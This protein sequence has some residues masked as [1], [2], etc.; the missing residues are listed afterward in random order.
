MPQESQSPSPQPDTGMSPVPVEQLD[1]DNSQA[2][3][4][5]ETLI[6]EISIDGMC[7]VY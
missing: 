6:E 4:A 7:G 3:L 1:A 5:T 2:P